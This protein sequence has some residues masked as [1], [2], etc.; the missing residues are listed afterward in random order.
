MKHGTRR[1]LSLLLSLALAL[2]ML[3]GMAWAAEG[4]DTVEIALSNGDFESGA[5][6]W[7][8]TGYKTI[9]SN[10]WGKNNSTNTLNLWLSKEEKADGAASYTVSSAEAGTYYFTYDLM[11]ADN[12]AQIGYTVTGTSDASLASGSPDFTGQ[13][14][15]WGDEDCWYTYTT[16]QFTLAEA[17]SIT[18]TLSTS[19]PAEWWG[20]L[21][22]LKLFRVIDEAE[23]DVPSDP[24]YKIAVA[25][26]ATQATAGGTVTLTATVT[27]DG[28]AISNLAGENLSVTTWLD[29]FADNGH[30]D[31]NS[32]AV[33]TDGTSLTPSV[34]LPS[35]GVY[36]LVTEL[37]DTTGE[38]W[39]VLGSVLTTITV[40]APAEQPEPVEAEI[41]VPYVTGAE[42]DGFIKGV[43]VSSLLSLLRSGVTFHDWDG[44]PLGDNDGDGTP[45]SVDAQGEAFMA[46]LAE[47]GVNWVRLRVWNNPFDAQGNGYG[48][49]NNDLNAAVTMGKWV[50]DAGMKVLI[51]FHYSDFWADPGKQQAPKAWADYSLEQKKKAIA[52]FTTDSLNALKEARVD[53]G[54]VQIGNETTNGI[55]GAS[56]WA[57]MSALFSAG[58]AAV[59][60]VD[61]NILVA[62]HFTNPERSGNYANFAMQLDRYEVDYDVFASSYYPYW[63]G[64]LENLTAVLKQVAVTYDK[65]VMVAETSWA[66]TLEDGDGHDNTVRAGN[67]DTGEDNNWAFSVQGQALEVANVAQAVADVGKNGLGLFYWEAAWIP[68]GNV[69]GLEGEAYEAQVAENR[70]LWEANGSGWASSYA[71]EYDPGDAGVWYGG[72]AVDNQAMFDFDGNP[73]ASLNVWKYMKT[74][75]VAPKRVEDVEQ[76]ALTLTQGAA[77]TLPATVTVT[78]NDGTSSA[79]A[80]TW[81][82]EGLALDA[83]ALGVYEVTGTLTVQEDEAE[84]A[85]TTT[86]TVTVVAPNLL[87]NPGFEE[88]N[89][90]YTLSEGF[91]K[92]ITNQESSN[93]RTGSYC[94]HFY[95]ASAI[96]GW[97]AEQTITLAPGVY[98]F[99]LYGQGGDVG[100][101]AD[102]HAYV[103]IGDTELKAPVNLTSWQVWDDPT[104]TFTLT[105]QTQVAVG[106]QITAAAGAWGSFD[107]WYLR[108]HTHTLTHVTAQKPTATEPGNVEYWHCAGCGKYFADGAGT[109]EISRE[110]TVLPVVKPEPVP[111]PTPSTKPGQGE[112]TVLP[113]GTRVNV[114]TDQE[115]GAVTTTQTRPDGVKIVS[116][117]QPGE[118][119]TASVTLPGGVSEATVSIPVEDPTPGTVAVL[120]YGDG[121]REVVRKSVVT[122]E[123]VVL[124]LDG[125]AALEIVDNSK[126]FA[127]VPATQWYAQ[128]V[129]FVSARSLFQGTGASTFHPQG[130]M[131]RAMLAQV[132]YNLEGNPP[133]EADAAFADVP[134]GAW[135]CQAVAWAAEEGVMGGYGGGAFGSDDFI[136][137]E[138]LAVILYRSAGMPQAGHD[139]LE[140][141]TDAGEISDW[142]I[143]AMT[144]AVETGL[145]Q[146]N[147]SGLNPGGYATRA[148][149]AA[150]MQRFCTQ[151]VMNA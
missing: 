141:F 45:D 55:C 31:G 63:H 26:S 89:T 106:V 119:V 130:T 43:D 47:A 94:L 73:L 20:N 15:G 59:R 56:G 116:V 105:E 150:M 85:Y 5:E 41:I 82:T 95:S 87:Q 97:T 100:E 69:S 144:W 142:A 25:S 149:V 117:A 65:Q 24:Q 110:D 123:G 118:A 4:P 48:G 114:V 145:L 104:I 16:E 103:K 92:G 67:N 98:E 12:T 1:L 113:D 115:T 61:K 18:F 148:E 46:L 78:Y 143:Q 14:L 8:L 27:K 107:D 34:T 2:G 138:Q 40:T 124:T 83:L 133:V 17:G 80:V 132:L 126:D 53:V 77:L 13:T 9:A 108:V 39:T 23:P 146:G 99:T 54:M 62:I 42:S 127:D 139:G 66:T 79:V 131:T 91:S 137:R 111:T 90:G 19:Q 71:G 29:Y 112:T 21:D 147:G 122:E 74:G 135:Y 7:S 93:N 72:S 88:G 58:A 50:T 37:Y 51:D 121:S 134:A 96:Q 125:S 52:Q 140:D 136:T 3:P 30:G 11:V 101:E 86:C 57:N 38:T 60:A 64:S 151:E 76:P 6:S 33:I 75:T 44:E 28:T 70:Q 32:D 120:V 102:I 22:N 68:V 36:Y 109:E 128:A 81:D 84:K 35:K 49:G 129:D 10:E